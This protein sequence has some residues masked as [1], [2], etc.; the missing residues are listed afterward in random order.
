MLNRITT[1]HQTD[2]ELVE[3]HLPCPLCPSSDAYS[4]YTDGHGYCFSC[5]EIHPKSF[6][7]REFN[8][9]DDCTYEYIARRGLTKE[10]Y[11]FYDAKTKIN[12]EGEPVEIGYR[13]ALPQP[14]R[15][16]T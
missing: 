5:L 2:S 10:T 7:Q 15:L 13:Y 14:I 12:S 1:S 8:L 9:S 11:A 4:T 6:K 3:A 16:G